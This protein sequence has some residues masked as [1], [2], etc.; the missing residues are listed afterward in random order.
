MDHFGSPLLEQKDNREISEITEFCALFV[1]Y[2]LIFTE[3]KVL[4]LNFSYY[5]LFSLQ[6]GFS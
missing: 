4:I 2:L 1:R 3:V 5:S 6:F